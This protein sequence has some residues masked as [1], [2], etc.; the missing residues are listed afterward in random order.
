MKKFWFKFLVS[1][2][3]GNIMALVD[4]MNAGLEISRKEVEKKRRMINRLQE[5]LNTQ[6]RT[7]NV[8]EENL[9]IDERS[10]RSFEDTN[11]APTITID[12]IVDLV[13]DNRKIEAIKALRNRKMC[14]S[15]SK[16][17]VEMLANK[18]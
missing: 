1:F 17:I 16:Q 18:E 4:L 12:Y 13:N 11:N 15:D 14:L 3:K 8:L 7:L 10:V 2:S 6:K 5:K 9:E